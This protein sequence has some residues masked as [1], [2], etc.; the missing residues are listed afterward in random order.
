MF[1]IGFHFDF[2]FM[3]VYLLVILSAAN[4]T[5]TVSDSHWNLVNDWLIFTCLSD[6]G[7]VFRIYCATYVIGYWLAMYAL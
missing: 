5:V 6:G 7:A 1:D 3:C 2:G 4:I